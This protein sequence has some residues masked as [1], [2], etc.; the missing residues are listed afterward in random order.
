MKTITTDIAVIGAGGAGLRTAIAAAEANPDLEIALISKVY[1]M[2]SHTVAAEG[3]SAAVIKDEDSLDNHFNDTVGG[4]DWLCEQDVVEYFV[5]NATREM[6]QLEQWGCPWSRKENGDVNVR[7]FGGMKVERTWFAADKTGFH[8]LHTLFQTSIKYDQI[9]RYDEYFV[10]DLL[11]EEGEVQGLVAIHMAEGELICIKAKSVVL[12]TGGAGRVYNCNTNGGIVTGDGMAMAF[13]HGVPLRDMEFVQ[14]HPTG[15]PGTGILMTEG[16][17]G[18]GGIIVNKDGYRYLQDYGMGP[19]TPVGQPKNKY[20]ELGPRDKVS[21][22]FWHELQ[23]GNTIK[24]PLGDV[25]HLDLRHLGE[26]YLHERLPFICELS[27]AYVN[28][29]PAK[30]P[31]PIRP[32][33]HYTMGGI[34]TDKHNE[35]RIKGLF[36]VG[37]CSSVGLHGANRLGSN[38]LAELV[39]FGRLAGEGAVKRAEEFKG[40]NEESI[41]K[42][43]QAIQDRIDTLMAQEG[44]ENW[45]DIRTEMGHS[46]EAGCGIYRQEDLMQATVEKLA[47]LRKRFKNIS[48]KDKGKVFNTDLLYAIEVGYGLEV[49]EAMAHS[50]IQRKESRGAHQRL[51]EGCTERDDENYLKHTLAFF[52][53]DDAPRIEYSDVTI[54]KSQPKARLY[55]AAAEEA[56]AKEAAEAAANKEEQA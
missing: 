54:T 28:V 15:L 8:M 25:V 43:I 3:G 46:M 38:S 52:N 37:E 7:R 6:T 16:C 1:P 40:W 19:E 51:D 56:A 23:K 10:V 35:T 20:M 48:I 44:D 49:A 24:H 9:K 5:E 2:R 55:G 53:G 50:A 4:G 33:V 17:R 39:V 27:K 18:E 47:E 13:R 31:I 32:T 45:A 22:A 14:Y 36:A 12:A 26:E 11:V 34:E 30:E 41:T 21:Q 29:D 42:Q